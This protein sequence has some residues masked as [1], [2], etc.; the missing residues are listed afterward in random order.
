VESDHVVDDETAIVAYVIEAQRV[1]ASG[2]KGV[3]RMTKC[4]DCNEYIGSADGAHLLYMGYI[5][6]GCKGTLWEY[7]NVRTTDTT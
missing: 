7:N 4:P 3:R 1:L 2:A 5:I 6:I